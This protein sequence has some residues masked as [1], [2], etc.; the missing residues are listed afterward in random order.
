[1]AGTLAIVALV[2]SGLLL[3][4]M[5]L[6]LVLLRKGEGPRYSASQAYE[7]HR[8][9]ALRALTGEEVDALPGGQWYAPAFDEAGAG[10]E[11]AA[12]HRELAREALLAVAPKNAGL[13][14]DERGGA[15]LEGG[16]VRVFPAVSTA[17][18]READLPDRET[19]RLAVGLVLFN[20]EPPGGEATSVTLPVQALFPALE[21]AG[22]HDIVGRFE[23]L[24]D[25]AS[26]RLTIL[27]GGSDT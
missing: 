19:G 22:R 5:I 25:E 23:A 24:R 18:L 4:T 1:M 8:R 21:R 20:P 17:A 26:S 9:D 2:V 12:S 3:G 10:G 27:R 14:F 13:T 16:Q 7:S 6:A 11:L 15:V